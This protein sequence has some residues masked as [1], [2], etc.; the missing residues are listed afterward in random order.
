MEQ[1]ARFYQL[2]DSVR[3]AVNTALALGEPLLVTGEPGTGKTQLAYYLAEKLDCGPV[4]RF[5]VKS[6]AQANDVLY[7][8]D[9]VRYFHAGRGEVGTGLD[10]RDFREKGVLWKAIESDRPRV[11]LIDEIDKAPRDFPNDLLQAL[12][13]Y[14]WTVLETGEHQRLPSDKWDLRPVVIITS[15]EEHKLPAAFLRRCLHCHIPFT[16]RLLA[17]AVA[18]RAE[19]LGSPSQSFVELALKR[20]MEVR[21]V[22]VRKRPSTAEALVWLRTLHVFGVEEAQLHSAL[23][24]LPHLE[25][26]LKEE[27]ERELLK[28]RG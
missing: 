26:L 21:E 5:Q 20:F 4:L 22:V 15:N 9:A 25:A 13:E 19:E 23:E 18:A 2:D 12:D 14:Q 16:P 17:R 7:Q 28:R 6:T 27:E 1:G 8:F 10:P 11:V 3:V 24:E